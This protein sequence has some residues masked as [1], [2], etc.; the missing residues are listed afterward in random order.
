MIHTLWNFGG[1]DAY[2]GAEPIDIEDSAMR[3]RSNI[4][5]TANWLVELS[6]KN[7]SI[8]WKSKNTTDNGQH[9]SLI[10]VEG[11]KHVVQ[12]C[13][14]F[15]FEHL[16]GLKNVFAENIIPA[17][18]VLGKMQS[19]GKIIDS[20]RLKVHADLLYHNGILL[21]RYLLSHAKKGNYMSND[22]IE[23]PQSSV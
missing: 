12:K 16:H 22:Y 8:Y 11:F 9:Y 1:L 18:E 13:A 14:L 15:E 10:I 20:H 4:I 17:L 2:K 23:A 19:D 6:Q 5:T 21:F 3:L 7:R